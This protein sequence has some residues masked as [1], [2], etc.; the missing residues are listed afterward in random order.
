M[1]AKQ[2]FDMSDF[3]L[4]IWQTG[5]G[6]Q[7]NM[8]VNEVIANRANIEL[9]KIVYPPGETPLLLLRVHPNDHVN[10]G[11]S[12]ND[13][14]PTAMQIAA[15]H[16]HHK[17]VMPSL[18]SLWHYLKQKEDAF[19]II[20]VGR[21][22]TQDATPIRT[23]QEFSGFRASLEFWILEA[24]R[25]ARN[26]RFLAQ[27]GTAV[28]TG[29]NCEKGFDSKFCQKLNELY[30]EEICFR[31]LAECCP[32]VQKIQIGNFRISYIK[33]LIYHYHT[34]KYPLTTPK[35]TTQTPKSIQHVLTLFS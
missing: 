26:M 25:C 12:S 17:Q 32:N 22:H 5:S 28:G 24:D 27:G 34:Q 19:E 8:N 3:P 20:K 15:L 7:T 14:F 10:K 13:T 35:I 1:L 16:K 21:T 23:G 6:T 33:I 31:T 11:Q 29:M 2:P 18:L 4:S 9:Q 30:M